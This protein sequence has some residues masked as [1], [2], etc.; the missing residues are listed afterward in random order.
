MIKAVIFDLDGTLLDDSPALRAG[1]AA[2][3]RY[4]PAVA[5]LSDGE[6]I[7]LWQGRRSATC[8]P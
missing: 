4:L 5:G 7:A 8:S 6:L 3:Q 2:V 1:L